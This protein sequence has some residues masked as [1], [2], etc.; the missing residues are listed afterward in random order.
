[1]GQI[2][3]EGMDESGILPRARYAMTVVESGGRCKPPS[4]SKGRALMGVQEVKP[5]A[6]TILQY[7]V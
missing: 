4:G 7:P 2:C 5:E 1:M 3:R 6:L